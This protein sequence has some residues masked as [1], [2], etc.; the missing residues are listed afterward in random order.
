MMH[1]CIWGNRS[2]YLYLHCETKLPPLASLLQK[3]GILGQTMHEKGQQKVEPLPDHTTAPVGSLPMLNLTEDSQLAF[4]FA[5]LYLVV[6]LHSQKNSQATGEAKLQP[7][8][9]Y[10]QWGHS[11]LS[12]RRS[13]EYPCPALSEALTCGFVG[14]HGCQR[15]GICH[16]HFQAGILSE[17]L[18]L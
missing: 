10:L 5:L 6:F 1:P 3:G 13:S 17:E 12:R 8:W 16:F 7:T 9:T 11:F 2:S 15:I 18:S 4:A 14:G